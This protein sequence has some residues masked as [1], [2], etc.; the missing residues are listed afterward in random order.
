MIRLV[1]V[2]FAMIIFAA[3]GQA[4]PTDTVATLPITLTETNAPP[5]QTTIPTVATKTSQPT[6]TFA[7]PTSTVVPQTNPLLS[8]TPTRVK[9][10]RT[11]TP[12]YSA[13]NVAQMEIAI[14]EESEN[15]VCQLFEREEAA[16]FLG[17]P[18]T[19][20]SS[21]SF[22]LDPGPSSKDEPVRVIV[23]AYYSGS[24]PGLV[25]VASFNP[26]VSEV[27]PAQFFEREKNLTTKPIKITIV[28]GVGDEAFGKT[29]SSYLYFRKGNKYFSVQIGG[30]EWLA[31]SQA[32][33][34][35]M[36]ERLPDQ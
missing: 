24:P 29:P 26:I 34:R 23:C 16:T 8:R 18:V 6:R 22:R 7:P 1:P 10:T 21:G 32:I 25:T 28:N 3:C 19:K 36:L 13:T 17:A 9:P 27:G 2:V 33:A 31:R 4:A 30:P 15:P 35:I 14:I 5:S 11:S 20:V 12:N